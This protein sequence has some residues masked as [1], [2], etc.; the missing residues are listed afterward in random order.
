MYSVASRQVRTCHALQ[1]DS[2]FKYCFHGASVYQ[3]EL[4]PE[5][6][7][8]IV[9]LHPILCL[10]SEGLTRTDMPITLQH[11]RS[12]NGCDTLRYTHTYLC[13]DVYFNYSTMIWEHL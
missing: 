9:G 8:G 10:T 12:K 13:S 3:H 1:K 7:L 6:T 5:N 4:F 2:D 11:V